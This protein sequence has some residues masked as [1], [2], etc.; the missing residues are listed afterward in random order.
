MTI[1]DSDIFNKNELRTIMKF[2][3]LK[4][5]A[6]DVILQEITEVCGEES[7]K[8]RTVQK[9]TSRFRMNDFSVEDKT[10]VGCPINENLR[11]QVKKCIKNDPHQSTLAIAHELNCSKD[12][13]KKI[14]KDELGNE[15][16]QHS[17]DS[18]HSHKF[19]TSSKSTRITRDVETTI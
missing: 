13:V 11:P 5:L 7:T 18:T 14:L 19:A 4:G 2:L 1:I 16:S 9:W 15:K 3:F 12:T 8:L 10:R 17:M 6:N